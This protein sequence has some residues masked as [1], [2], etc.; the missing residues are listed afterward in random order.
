LQK[1]HQQELENLYS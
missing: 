1:H